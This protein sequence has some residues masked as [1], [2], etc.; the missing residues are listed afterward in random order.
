MATWLYSVPHIKL[1]FLLVWWYN[2][3]KMR[4][5]LVWGEAF[6]LFNCWQLTAPTKVWTKIRKCFRVIVLIR[7]KAI[8][9][10]SFTVGFRSSVTRLGEFCNN[11]FTKLTKMFGGFLG[12]F[13]KRCFLSQTGEAT[14]CG[15]FWHN[16]GYFI[17]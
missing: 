2:L 15:N 17:F 8:C 13:E 16:L 4:L 3:V 1:C 14:F 5:S 11:F 9:W 7:M 10:V 6:L 12:S